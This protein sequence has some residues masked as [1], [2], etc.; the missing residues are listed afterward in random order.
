MR[1]KNNNH[2]TRYNEIISKMK[3]TDCYHRAFAYLIALDE[4]ITGKKINDCFDFKE[5][6]I[7]PV[8]EPWLTG[9]DRSVLMLAFHLWNDCHQ[10]NLDRVFG[11]D[12]EYLLEAIKIRYC[13]G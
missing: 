5:D 6:C 3:S 7:K 4:N 2:E 10:I 9:F 8:D 12:D 11:S 13:I 1:F